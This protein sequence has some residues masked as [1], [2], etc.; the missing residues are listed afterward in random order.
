M[1]R[2]LNWLVWMTA[3]LGLSPVEESPRPDPE[4]SQKGPGAPASMFGGGCEVD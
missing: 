3:A 2:K 4:N 1:A